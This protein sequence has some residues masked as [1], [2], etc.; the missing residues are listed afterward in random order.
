MEPIPVL[1]LAQQLTQGG[2]ERQLTETA[3]A[4][5]R[6]RFSPRTA[7]FRRGGLRVE[8]L[9]AS[10]VPVIEFPLQS[11]VSPKTLE[12]AWQLRRYIR[13]QRIQLVHSFDTPMNAFAMPVA[14]VS[15]ASVALSSQR[16]FREL[17][18]PM[19]RKM[20]RFTDRI[21]DAIVVNCHA[22]EKH[23]INDEGVAPERIRLCYNGID[24]DTFKPAAARVREECVIG[25]VCALRPE[26]GLP[27]LV[28]AFARVHRP[29]LR[30]LIV[31]SG[32]VLP[33]LKALAEQLGISAHCTFEPAT[34]EVTP[35]LHAI[36]IFVLPSRSE[37]LS[38][39]LMEAMACGCAAV[40]SKVGGNPELVEPGNTGLLFTPLDAADLAAQL[41]ILIDEPEARRKMAE[42][43]CRKIHENFRLRDATRR[44]TEIYLEFLA[45][46]ST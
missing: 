13:E 26:K 3:K 9:R 34:S 40:A 28:E 32:P 12:Q 1:L 20:L 8:E 39:S 44:M 38:N 14:K 16:A 11:F 35:W 21:V 36:D 6:E 30:L 33:D 18:T 29:G 27:T 22:L 10:G 41:R 25:V 17:S 2:S 15:G 43:G 24:T 45:R 19:F 46:K 4:L 31:G 7:V 42:N 5:D 23:L 37:A